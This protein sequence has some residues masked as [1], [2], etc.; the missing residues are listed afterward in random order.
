MRPSRLAGLVAVAALLAGCFSMSPA[1]NK[2]LDEVRAFADDTARL[3]G[4]PQIH[5]LV[6]HNP[7]SPVGSYR[8][9]FFAVNQLVL[10]SEFRDAIVAHELA[11]YVLGHDAALAAPTPEARL[12][13]RQQRELDANAKSVEI[14][15]RVRG[16]PED[17]ALRMAYSYLLNVHRR[18]QRS[19][20]EDL[21]GH[22]P[23]CEEIADL[24]ARYPAQLTW[25]SGLECA[26]GG[27]AAAR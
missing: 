16:V 11:H 7:D 27:A 4:L 6:S 3:Y 2:S 23:P 13:E 1:Q 20:G 19:P 15:T 18:L 9:G 24:L 21:L 14:L 12:A 10:R 8:R 5:V 17:Q 25:T 22:R 26:P